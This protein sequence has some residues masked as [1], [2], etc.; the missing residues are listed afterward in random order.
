[1]FKTCKSPFFYNYLIDCMT[2]M[3]YN[4]IGWQT[5]GG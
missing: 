3:N 5:V 2:G 4:T 1:M